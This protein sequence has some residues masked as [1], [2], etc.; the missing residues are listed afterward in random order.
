MKEK[1]SEEARQGRPRSPR[2]SQSPQQ[3]A[4]VL[5][6]FPCGL[7]PTQGRSPGGHGGRAAS[8]SSKACRS[9]AWSDPM[10]TARCPIHLT[11]AQDRLELPFTDANSVGVVLSFLEHLKVGKRVLYYVKSLPWC[12]V[13]F[14]PGLRVVVI[15]GFHF[16]T[17]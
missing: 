1:V 10:P 17:F 14:L 5:T 15:T 12:F 7:R 3:A 4:G 13:C 9:W 2:P 11:D 8:S 16:L 6:W